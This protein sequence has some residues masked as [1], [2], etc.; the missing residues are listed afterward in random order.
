MLGNGVGISDKSMRGPSMS[1]ACLILRPLHLRRNLQPDQGRGSG[2]R[3]RYG[4]RHFE[5]VP[6][7]FRERPH[8]QL[9]TGLL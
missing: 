9:N 1:P 5:F 2:L 6:T 4:N 8:I 3:V 7:V